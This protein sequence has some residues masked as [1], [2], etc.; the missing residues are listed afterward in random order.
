[1]TAIHHN[2]P[3]PVKIQND[4]LHLDFF[5]SPGDD[6]FTD[7]EEGEYKSGLI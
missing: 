7:K 4:S 2:L 3:Q 6:L 5:S 1:M